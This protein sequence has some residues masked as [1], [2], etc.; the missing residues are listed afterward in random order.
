[1]DGFIMVPM[2]VFDSSLSNKSSLLL[3][4]LISNSKQYGYAYGRNQY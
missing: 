3:G 2:S 4:I 1:M